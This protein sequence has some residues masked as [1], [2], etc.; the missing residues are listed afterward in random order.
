MNKR[1]IVGA[2]STAFLAAREVGY[3]KSRNPEAGGGRGSQ[4]ARLFAVKSIPRLI[5]TWMPPQPQKRYVTPNIGGCAASL[6]LVDL[7]PRRHPALDEFG[8]T[9]LAAG[10]LPSFTRILP[11]AVGGSTVTRGN[12]RR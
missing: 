5:V 3:L 11:Q 1:C 12:R 9:A 10:A 7:A 8:R 6:G 4:R 2:R